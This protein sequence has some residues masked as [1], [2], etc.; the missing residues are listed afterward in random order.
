VATAAPAIIRRVAEKF[1]RL[2][3]D[4]ILYFPC[5]VQLLYPGV[6]GRIVNPVVP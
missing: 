1:V 5:K 6:V 3:S 2:L 4:G